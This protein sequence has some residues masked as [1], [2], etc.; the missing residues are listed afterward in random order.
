M[1]LLA[2]S[3]PSRMTQVARLL[4]ILLTSAFLLACSKDDKAPPRQLL[5]LSLPYTT[6]DRPLFVAVQD[7]RP[8]LLTGSITPSEI[9]VHR[10]LIGIPW[11]A[12]TASGAPLAH[13]LGRTLTASLRSIAVNALQVNVEPGSMPEE[14]VERAFL[15]GDDP[16]GLVLHFLVTK[17][18]SETGW[19]TTLDYCIELQLRTLVGESLGTASECRCESIGEDNPQFRNM[20]VATSTI[21]GRLLVAEPISRILSKSK[22]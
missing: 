9:G 20:V 21:F 3:Y 22:R 4:I 10:S 15:F 5:R 8:Q 16:T 13:V 2:L 1:L 12:T 6:G 11:K 14:T 7:V 17:W 18:R 19:S